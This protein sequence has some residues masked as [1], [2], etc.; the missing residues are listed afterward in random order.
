MFNSK[1]IFLLLFAFMPFSLFGQEMLEG[2]AAIVGD[3]I[4]LHSEVNQ[5]ATQLA[6]QSKV[7]LQKEPAK[8]E[9]LKKMSRE[10][11]VVQK[12]LLAKAREDTVMVDDAQVEDVLNNQ[13]QTWVQSMG[14]EAKIEEYFGMPVSRIKRQF[15][16]EVRNR[17][18]VE[19]LQSLHVQ[20]ITVTRPEVEN[21]Y[22]TNKD[23]LP[24]IKDMVE[25]F[26]ILREIRA[27]G[28]GREESLKKIKDIRQR[29]IDGEEFE[30][31]AKLYSEDPGSA[32]RGGELG[33]IQ[34]GD[35]V[36]EFEEVAF[37]LK[38][39][40]I[41]DIVETKFGFHVIQLIE[42]RGERINA[43]HVLIQLQASGDDAEVTKAFLATIRDSVLAGA[44]FGKMAK[45]YSADKTSSDIDGSLGWFELEQLQIDEFKNAVKDLDKGGISEPFRTDF[46]FHIIKVNDK[47]DGG[48]L[49]LEKDWQQVEQIALGQKRNKEMVRWIDELREQVYIEVKE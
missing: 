18:M 19:S 37:N 22:T 20:K 15:R 2:I 12:I 21:F 38:A 46:G 10:N 47:R 39:D 30:A 26:H 4:I 9:E 49:T 25:I 31:L 42:R 41:S 33:F 32:R 3:E 5:F 13:I 45:K 14:S 43:R 16:D 44:D 40:E 7:D 6:I 11:L 48:K 24:D 28:E 8:F 34:R 1:K 23:S 17:L 29:I 36:T 35:F 27:G